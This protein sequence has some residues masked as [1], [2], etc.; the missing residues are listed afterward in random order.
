[1]KKTI[2]TILISLM[3]GSS[4][5][6]CN[7]P[8]FKSIKDVKLK[9]DFTPG[10]VDKALFDIT[11]QT[12]DNYIVAL[13][14]VT[15]LG[16]A[17]TSNFELFD[18]ENLNSSLIFDFTDTETIHSLMQGESVPD[19]NY[20]SVKIEIYYLQMKINI[21]SSTEIAKRN[22]RIYLSEEETHK[23]GDITQ[24]NN[25]N[26]EEG[27]LLGNGLNPDMQPI[28][29]RTVAYSID[30]NGDGLGDGVSWFDFA[31]KPAN[32]FGP[33]GDVDFMNNDPHPIYYT[34]L[35]FDLVDKNGTDI[36]IDF[37]V[38]EC[39]QFEDK[40]KNGAF[41]YGDLSFDNDNT[42]WHM[43]LPEMTVTLE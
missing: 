18:S 2:Y 12:P 32:N 21:S 14:K 27:W 28:S 41:G 39:W 23:P 1:M 37:N 3:I 13:K 26:V 31:G 10:A 35:F 36:I 34:V 33:F 4:F 24:I 6:S 30:D 22:L 15:L 25:S 17:G 19:G 16:D 9:V 7:K 5:T 29:P 8:R 20:S 42:K 40:D 43:A 38:N 11:K